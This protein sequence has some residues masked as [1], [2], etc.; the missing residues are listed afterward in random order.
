MGIGLPPLLVCA[1]MDV[2]PR[3]EVYSIQCI[4]IWWAHMQSNTPNNWKSKRADIFAS[5]ETQVERVA[6]LFD[7]PET[8]RTP[9]Q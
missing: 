3:N 9:R 1:H 5:P 4:V 6:S 8:P 7:T 2:K